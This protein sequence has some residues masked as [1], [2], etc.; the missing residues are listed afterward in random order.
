MGA[1]LDKHRRTARACGGAMAMDKASR[2]AYVLAVEKAVRAKQRA[3]HARAFIPPSPNCASGTWHT[4]GEEIG[5]AVAA[6]NRAR[7]NAAAMRDRSKRTPRQWQEMYDAAMQE[8][9]STT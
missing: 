2:D 9:R 7:A 6:Q 5:R 8:K 4:T 3:E 1:G